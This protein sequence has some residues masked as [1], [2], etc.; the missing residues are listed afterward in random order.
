M[1][2]LNYIFF[3]EDGLKVCQVVG[4][5]LHL[6]FSLHNSFQPPNRIFFFYSPLKLTATG[7]CLPPVVAMVA[8]M[9]TLITADL[10]SSFPE[11]ADTLTP[12]DDM[13]STGSTPPPMNKL[14]G[15]VREETSRHPSPQP[16]HISASVPRTGGN[17]HRILRSATVG[18]VA[19]EFKGRSQQMKEGELTCRSSV[20]PMLWCLSYISV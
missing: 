14:I 2:L 11:Y 13:S 3:S 18:Y 15:K 4:I 20:I 6:I 19:P 9:L 16:S 8:K 17:G 12:D 7:G 5:S 10:P 1:S